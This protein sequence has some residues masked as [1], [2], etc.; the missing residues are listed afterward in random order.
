MAQEQQAT[1]MWH[2][3]AEG[4]EGWP[5]AHPLL[6]SSLQ[7]QLLFRVGLPCS[8]KAS[9]KHSID[10]ARAVF[11]C[12]SKSCLADSEVTHHNTALW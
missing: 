9:R 10:T 2:Q 12:D 7:P 6:L 8:H 11:H 3:D 5:S 1:L 4:M